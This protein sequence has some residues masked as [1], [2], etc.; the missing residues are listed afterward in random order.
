MNDIDSILT[1]WLEP[2]P[3]N[4]AESDAA[5][6]KWFFHDAT[7]RRET[8]PAEAEYLAYLKAVGKWL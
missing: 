6:Q 2:K 8:T 7:L 3:T 1:F 4:A 5:W